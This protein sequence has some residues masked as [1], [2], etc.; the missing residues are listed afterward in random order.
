G[1]DNLATLGPDA[2]RTAAAIVAEITV[3]AVPTALGTT[4]WRGRAGD[5]AHEGEHPP[6]GGGSVGD[7]AREGAQAA[8]AEA[9][10]ACETA[11]GDRLATAEA[12]GA[13]R[14]RIN[15]VGR[16]ARNQPS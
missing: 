15:R 1:V 9:G 10:T 7:A 2:L 8:P 5:G 11:E 16:T 12:T 6:D 3:V 13:D 14:P 4:W